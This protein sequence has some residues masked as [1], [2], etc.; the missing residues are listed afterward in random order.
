MLKGLYI[1]CTGM[2]NEQRRV[3]ALSNNLANASTTGYKKEGTTSEAFSDVLALKIK[4][5]S[6]PL[7]ARRLGV[8]NMGVKLGETYTD[9]DQGPFHETGNTFDMALSGKGFFTI[10]FTN[11]AGE[12]SVKYTR[13]GAFKLNVNG[14][15]VNNNGDFVLDVNGNHIVLDPTQDF[16]V[17]RLGNITQGEG[18]NA[19]AQVNVVDFADYDFLEKYGETYYQPVD[20][21]QFVP[22]DAQIY[23]GYLETSNVQTVHEMVELISYQRAYESNQKI[24]QAYDESLGIAVEQLGRVS[25]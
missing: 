25:G 11:K 8:M 4:D 15:L 14:E 12:T 24:I 16:T 18:V 3:D 6:E 22:A 5:T 23:S 9:Y 19:L 21:A 1:A 20:G 13:D 10:E 7:T 17:D 2:V